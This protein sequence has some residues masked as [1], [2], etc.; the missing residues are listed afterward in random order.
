MRVG[1]YICC[2]FSV[3]DNKNFIKLDPLPSAN[4]SYYNYPHLAEAAGNW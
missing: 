2:S 1:I 3:G 4:A